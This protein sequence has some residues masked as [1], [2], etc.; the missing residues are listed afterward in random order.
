MSVVAALLQVF[1]LFEEIRGYLLVEE[2]PQEL[3]RLDCMTLMYEAAQRI[4]ARLLT[5]LDE[6]ETRFF[7]T[8]PYGAVPCKEW[9][10]NKMQKFPTPKI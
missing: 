3:S 7:D 1:S 9:L 6:A 2:D 8:I 10:V 4:D 5:S